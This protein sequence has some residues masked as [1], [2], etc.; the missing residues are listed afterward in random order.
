MDNALQELRSFFGW[1]RDSNMPLLYS[2]AVFEDRLSSIWNS[3][4]DEH[5]AVLRAI[6][7]GQNEA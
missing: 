5:V 2:R 7:R 1:S 4:F 6:P 3:K